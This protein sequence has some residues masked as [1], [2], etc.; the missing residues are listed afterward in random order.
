MPVPPLLQRGDLE[1]LL[2]PLGEGPV[3][4][5]LVLVKRRPAQEHLELL[6]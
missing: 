2:L 3:L 4:H 5:G 1:E 6:V